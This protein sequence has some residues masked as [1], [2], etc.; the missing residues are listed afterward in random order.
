MRVPPPLDRAPK[1]RQPSAH[2]WF[3]ALRSGF[4]SREAC[5]RPAGKPRSAGPPKSGPGWRRYGSPP[6]GCP[7]PSRLGPDA[8]GRTRGKAGHR[9]AGSTFRPPCSMTGNDRQKITGPPVGSTSAGCPGRSP[10]RGSPPTVTGD[11]AVVGG[12]SP[13]ADPAFR[14]PHPPAAP[15]T[16]ANALAR[17][18][19]PRPLSGPGARDP[20][21]AEPR[22]RRRSDRRALLQET[23]ESIL[24]G[25]RR[26]GIP[27][28]R[29]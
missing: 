8:P 19:T 24:R 20:A 29:R 1:D 10:L 5:R 15:Y 12:P 17:V 25:Q 4:G 2:S 21:P 27:I 16:P 28:H 6:R 23:G 26:L 22:R 9:E 18:G 14:R 11:A 13:R 3:V 7:T